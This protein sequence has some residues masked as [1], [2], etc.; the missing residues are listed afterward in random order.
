[1][2][3]NT[4][5]PDNILER[6]AEVWM[7]LLRSPEY[8][9]GERGFPQKA[10]MLSMT[11]KLKPNLT[12]EELQAFKRELFIILRD[13]HDTQWGRDFPTHLGVD[14]GECPALA[15]AAAR[16]GVTIKLWPFKTNVYIRRDSVGVSAGYAAEEVNHYP[17]PDG[18]WLMTRLSGTDMPKVIALAAAGQGEWDIEEVK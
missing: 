10:F 3:R 13:G 18:R 8:E 17:M 15:V 16:A 9:N 11:D 4:P 12:E 6:A 7:R 14:Y 2:L 5:V 1:M